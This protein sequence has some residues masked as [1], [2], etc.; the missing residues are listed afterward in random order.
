MTQIDYS[1]KN[2]GSFPQISI[3]KSDFTLD[4]CGKHRKAETDY[5]EGS[6]NL[7]FTTDAPCGEWNVLIFIIVII[8]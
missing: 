6:V 2:V 1:L 3:G 4:I 8:Q 5:A 7:Y